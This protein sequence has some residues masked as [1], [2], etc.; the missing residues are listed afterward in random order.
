MGKPLDLP[1]LAANKDD[2]L[3]AATVLALETD[4][5]ARAFA[6]ARRSASRRPRS[7]SLSAI[8]GCTS[9]LRP[10]SWSS[11][12]A[13][14]RASGCATLA[15]GTPASSRCR[16]T[17]ASWR[18]AGSNGPSRRCSRDFSSGSSGGTTPRPAC[19]AS[20]RTTSKWSSSPCASCSTCGRRP[21]SPGPIPRCCAATREQGGLNLVSGAAN[22]A[23]DCGAKCS[24]SRRPGRENFQPGSRS[25]LTPGNVVLRNRLIE[26]IQYAPTTDTVHAEPVL[27]VPAWIMKYYILDLSPAQLAG[28]YLVEHGHTVFMISW[29]NPGAA[30]RDLG[31]DDYRELGV[32]AGARR[33]RPRSC[34]GARSTRPATASAARCWRSPPPRMARDGDERLASLT[35]LAAQTDFTEAG[36]ARCCSSTRARSAFLE[37]MMC[38]AGLPRRAPDGGRVPAAALER[39]DLV[40][41]R[42]RLPARA[43]A[44]R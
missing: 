25:R 15:T 17:G 10:E 34:R 21:I 33:D 30:D 23:D 4:R 12:S 26:L 32:M 28:R 27:I 38:A 22:F 16:R 3:D 20:R 41:P 35:L 13:R 9:P 24:A 19:A 18:P 43:S 2:E 36:R 42:P 6:R 14:R 1:G 7:R 39:P 5:L 37:D 29:K 40:A 8:G 11:C 31:M 44:R